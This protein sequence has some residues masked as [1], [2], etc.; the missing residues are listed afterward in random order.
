MTAQPDSPTGNNKPIQGIGPLLRKYWLTAAA[1]FAA[2]VVSTAFYTLGQRKVFQAEGT[3][4]FDPTPPRAPTRKVETIVETGADS[5]WVNKTYYETQ[6]NIIRS[7]RVSLAVVNQLGLHNDLAFLQNLPKDEPPVVSASKTAPEHAADE[8]RSRVSVEP[9]RDSRLAVVKLRDANPERA[10]RILSTLIETYVAQ[11]L[12]VANESTAVANDWL[13]SRL[14]TLSSELRTNEQVLHDYKKR[15]DILSLA[16]DDKSNMLTDEMRVINH[17][18]TLV[19]T[20][21]QEAAARKTVLDSAPDNDPRLIQSSELLKSAVLT[22]LRSDYERAVME[23]DGLLGAGKGLNHHEVVSAET[24]V[25]SVEAAIIKEIRNVKAAVS[26]DLAVLSHQAD[27]LQRM[28]DKAKG[29]A[30]ELNALEIEHHRLR[31][32]KENNEKLYAQVL[33]R[34]KEISLTQMLRVNNISIVDPP[35]VPRRPVSPK[36]PLYMAVGI[37]GGLLLAVAAAFLRA[38]RDRTMNVPEDLKVNLGRGLLLR[39]GQFRFHR[40]ALGKG[41]ARQRARRRPTRQPGANA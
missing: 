6:Y 24:R 29:H 19:R 33:E 20:Q 36:V 27:G 7:R 41:R 23:R 12:D 37:F 21:M 31:R 16:F 25:K 3:V 30:A 13:R 22:L 5:Y 10:Q 34:K 40:E 18:L 11:N 4:L 38:Q 1:T 15:N 39:R 17:Q 32:N 2:V 26:R 14:D 8:L 28:L 35:L 9:I